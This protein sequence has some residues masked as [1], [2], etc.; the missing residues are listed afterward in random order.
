MRA[1]AVLCPGLLISGH[2]LSL[3]LWVD[4]TISL[5]MFSFLWKNL[6]CIY[7]HVGVYVYTGTMEATDPRAPGAEVTVLCWIWVL[8]SELRSSGRA[9]CHLPGEPSFSPSILLML[10]MYQRMA[11][12]S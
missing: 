7:V 11:L 2:C 3:P 9:L 1:A 6:E 10:A 5:T 8:G 4:L 12:N